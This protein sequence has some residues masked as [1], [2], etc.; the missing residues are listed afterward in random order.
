MQVNKT[1]GL[2][3]AKRDGF[4]KAITGRVGDKGEQYSFRLYNNGVVFDLALTTQITLTGLTP[5]GYY[6][7]AVCSKQTDGTVLA[8]IPSAFNVEMGYFQR[9]FIRVNTVT[10]DILSTQD[11]I[12]YSYGNADISAEHA[13]D[14]VGQIETLINQ[15]NEMADSLEADLT[16]QFRTLKT[17]L[18]KATSDLATLETKI[19]QF[20]AQ[21]DGTPLIF[22]NT[23]I[24]TQDWNTITNSGIYTLNGATGA[25]RPATT[26]RYGRLEVFANKMQRVTVDGGTIYYRVM[27]NAVST[28]GAWNQLATTTATIDAY[29]KAE[30]DSRFALKSTTYTKVEVDRAISASALDD[31]TLVHKTGA[32][33]IGGLKTFSTGLTVTGTT[34]LR[35]TNVLGAS[36][37]SQM[38]TVNSKKLQT[39]LTSENYT[40]FNMA[41]VDKTVL[42]SSTLTL[43]RVG[44]VAY[45]TGTAQFKGIGNNQQNI[46][47]KFP[48]NFQPYGSPS[49]GVTWSL[50]NWMD[51]GTAGGSVLTLAT[52]GTFSIYRNQ[53]NNTVYLNLMWLVAPV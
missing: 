30:S 23:S 46:I 15:I 44:N 5:S 34:S 41:G 27:N 1:L 21:F 25:N 11:L 31:T 51:G 35:A 48:A 49:T 19:D 36:T 29:T 2:D 3:L 9:C 20:M 42:L 22:N 4:T 7:E 17:N 14:Y 40:V 12:Y 26:V 39:E 32:E 6:V 28:W 43:S 13:K 24:T 18:D 50:W 47:V 16:N 37:F 53:T 45:L 10:G 8:T 52:D 33:T 38:P